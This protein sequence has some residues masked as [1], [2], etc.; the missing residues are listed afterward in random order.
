[1]VVLAMIRKPLPLSRLALLS[2]GAAACVALYCVLYTALAGRPETAAQAFAWATANILPWVVALEGAKRARTLIAV[3]AALA[4]GLA[5]SMAL[6]V[7]LFDA[8]HL[9]LDAWRR[10]PALLLVGG[11]AA[12]LRWAGPPQG[13]AASELPLLPRQIEWVRAAGNYVELR[14]K[15][16]GIIHRASLS[17]VQRQLADH[18]FIRVHRSLLVRRDCIARV[19]PT[20]LIL[21]DGTHLKTGK[22]YRAGLAD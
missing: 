17:A 10:V 4:G 2:A 22:R 3:A 16:R 7:V 19:R 1:V 20:D 8:S 14:A 9:L 5:L 11:I 15:G 18:G 12:A 21:L 13:A 6:E